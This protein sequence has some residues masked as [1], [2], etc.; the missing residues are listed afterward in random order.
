MNKS[1]ELQII[2]ILALLL[3]LMVSPVWAKKCLYVSSYHMGYEWDDGIYSSLEKT[4]NGRCEIKKI[5]LDTKRNPDEEWARWRSKEAIKVIDQ[6]KP[7]IIIAVDDNASRYLVMPY[8]KDADIPVVFCGINW[9]MSEYGY[10]YKNTTGMIEVSPIKQLIKQLK[11]LQPRVKKGIF[12]SSDVLSEQKDYK[13]YKPIF[14]KNGI[15]LEPVFVK[16]FREWREMYRK[17]QQYDFV[18]LGNNAGINDWY[19]HEALRIVNQYAKKISV[20]TYKWMLPYTAIA[21]TKLPEEQ[22][23]WAGRVTLSILG[24]VEPSQIPV[25]QNRQWDMWLNPGILKKIK[26]KIPYL[27]Y[28]RAKHY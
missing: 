4:I 14:A 11:L 20:T 6:Y 9:S 16:T 15:L 18:F 3:L 1:R 7:D 22:G 17:S 13:H 21:Y 25:I 10:P 28:K 19:K 23:I 26:L 8:L 12:L 27:I 24:G 5:Y 2:S